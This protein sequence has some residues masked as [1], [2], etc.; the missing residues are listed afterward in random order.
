MREKTKNAQLRHSD[1]LLEL[2]AHGKWKEESRFDF[3]VLYALVIFG[4]SPFERMEDMKVDHVLSSDIARRRHGESAVHF[5]LTETFGTGWHKARRR[6]DQTRHKKYTSRELAPHDRTAAP[7]I[8][9]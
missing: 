4:V 8:F 2:A 3:T 6:R 5:G 9:S 7:Y 1:A